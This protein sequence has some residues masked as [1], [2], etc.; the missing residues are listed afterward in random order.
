MHALRWPGFARG[1]VR[2]RRSAAGVGRPGSTIAPPSTLAEVDREEPRA[3]CML[4]P[5]PRRFPS[6]ALLCAGGLVCEQQPSG[7]FDIQTCR[8]SGGV[9][10]AQLGRT[11][12]GAC[13]HKGTIDVPV[14]ETSAS[15]LEVS[16]AP[17]VVRVSAVAEGSRKRTGQ[18]PY[19][20]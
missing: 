10:Y 3:R 2:R 12:L 15:R 17:A 8:E 7:P 20:E 13:Q 4:S 6:R 11:D 19:Q 9:M 14:Q 16:V 5:T 1:A 18:L